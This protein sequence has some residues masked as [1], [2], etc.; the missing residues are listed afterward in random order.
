MSDG[1]FYRAFRPRRLVGEDDL[2]V[3]IDGP[4]DQAT[5]KTLE[6]HS[7]FNYIKLNNK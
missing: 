6:F 2:T 1:Y 7:E 5:A 4:F 3:L